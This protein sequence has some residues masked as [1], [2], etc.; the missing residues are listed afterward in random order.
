MFEYLLWIPLAGGIVSL[1][2]FLPGFLILNL[3]PFKSRLNFSDVVIFS[4]G[5]GLI[6]LPLSVYWANVLGLPISFQGVLT[7]MTVILS[8][9]IACNALLIVLKR[10]KIASPEASQD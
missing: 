4:F 2:I 6:T 7:V 5:I 3:I 8:V 9:T 1:G 10:K